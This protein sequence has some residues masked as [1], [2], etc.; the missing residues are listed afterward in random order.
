MQLFIADI[1]A[2]GDGHIVGQWLEL[3]I[4]EDELD[5]VMKD[6]VSK[7]QN[8]HSDELLHEQ[9]VIIDYKAIIEVTI[10]D[11]I[12]ILNKI[13]K[14]IYDLLKFRFLISE[15]FLES[16]IL[17][18]GLDFYDVEIYDFRANNNSEDSFELLAKKFIANGIYDC[19]DYKKLAIDLRDNFT[20]FQK[21]VLGKWE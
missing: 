5:N 1:E 3:P 19:D 16:E 12:Y 11:N 15:A 20:E 18:N 13:A 10:Y 9:I 2:Y 6:I 21:G 4:N 14:N 7:K 8:I 17:E